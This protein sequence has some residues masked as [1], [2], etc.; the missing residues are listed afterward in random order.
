M[1]RTFSSP[2]SAISYGPILPPVNSMADGSLF[3]KTAPDSNGLNPLGLYIFNFQ[4]DI[5]PSVVGEQVGTGWQ[6]AAEANFDGGTIPDDVTVGGV[7]N[8]GSVTIVSSTTTNPGVIHFKNN[9]GIII[10]SLGWDATQSSLFVSGNWAFQNIPTTNVGGTF[11]TSDNDGVGSGLNADLLDGQHGAYYLDL[12]NATGNLNLSQVTG[13]LAAIN[14]GTGLVTT[15]AGGILYGAPGNTIAITA[16]GL[17]GQILQANGAAAPAWVNTSSISIGTATAATNISGGVAGDIPVQ[18]SPNVTTFIS[19]GPS[20]QV[21]TSTGTS[22]IPTWQTPS[23]GGG[24]VID[25]MNGS[26]PNVDHYL[27]FTPSTSTEPVSTLYTS[28]PQLLFNP[29]TGTLSSPEF[30]SLSD[31]RVKTNIRPLGY[32]LKEVMQMTGKKF[33]MISNNKTTIGFIAQDMQWIIPEAVSNNVDD[34]LGINY[35]LLTAVLVEAMKEQQ[36]QINEL[37]ALVA[38]LID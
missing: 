28:S 37:K 32:G 21:L 8:K 17:A 36:A 13:P 4:Q 26:G 9:S 33:E 3:F 25:D 16:A 29:F 14:G 20:G 38:K 2:T 18:S 34:K 22:S 31:R 12:A 11:W 5:N 19:A 35:Q 1:L 10:G 27:T 23:G 30:N 15:I 24:I 6:I 7:D